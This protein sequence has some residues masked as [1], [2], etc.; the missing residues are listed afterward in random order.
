MGG[1]GDEYGGGDEGVTLIDLVL[2]ELEDAPSEE[3]VGGSVVA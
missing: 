1:E 2:S 3:D